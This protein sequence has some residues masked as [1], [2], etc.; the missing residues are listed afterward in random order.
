MQRIRHLSL[1]FSVIELLIAVSV[2]AVIAA[3]AIPHYARARKSARS[4]DFTSELRTTA[5]AFQ[6]Y[7]AENNEFPPTTTALSKVPDGMDLYLPKNTTWESSPPIGGF[8]YWIHWPGGLWGYDGYVMLFLP[9][10]DREQMTLI[11]EKID[12]GVLTTGAFRASEE[13]WF[14][15][16]MK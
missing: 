5:E 9:D 15:L 4:A 13:K 6:M 2:V 3:I 8:W 7:A 14:V 10:A 16:G 11:D 1:G 12:D